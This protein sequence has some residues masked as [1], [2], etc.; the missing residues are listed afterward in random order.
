VYNERRSE[1]IC[2]ARTSGMK[3]GQASFNCPLKT[4]CQ[5]SRQV[6][7]PQLLPNNSNYFSTCTTEISRK[8]PRVT[9]QI[10]LQNRLQI[11]IQTQSL[12]L[13][14]WGYALS[15]KFGKA[16]MNWLFGNAQ[17][18]RMADIFVFEFH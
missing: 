9:T 15:E 14:S 11:Q 12:N 13:I 4:F 6:D 2:G 10:Q 16:T 1:Q 17:S 8:I 18:L 7:L 3:I 5:L